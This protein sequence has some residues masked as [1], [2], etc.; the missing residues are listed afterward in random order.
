MILGKSN[1]DFFLITELNLPDL[2]SIYLETVGTIFP[3][4]TSATDFAVNKLRVR[5]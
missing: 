4:L 2:I 3:T 1:L 5:L